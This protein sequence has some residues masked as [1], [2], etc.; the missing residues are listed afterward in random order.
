ALER[1]LADEGLRVGEWFGCLGDE[2]GW[3]SGEAVGAGLAG[4]G[5]TVGE[6]LSSVVSSQPKRL[7]VAD[8]ERR[9]SYGELWLRA[10]AV[11]R[12]L[13]TA[14][15]VPGERVGLVGG[16]DGPLLAG[17]LGIVLAG[18]AYVPLEPW[19]P[20]SRWEAVRAAQGLR[21]VVTVAGEAER[22]ASLGLPL[23]V[24][25]SLPADAGGEALVAVSP[26]APVYVLHTS[27]TTGAPRAVM[28]TQ[29]G[30]LW[31]LARY[32]GSL[33]LG[34]EDRL[35][36]LSGYGYDAALQDVFGALLSGA[37]LHAVDVQ[38][39]GLD[40]AG[41]LARLADAGVT[42]LHATP[43]VYRYLLGA[44]LS[45]RH[46]L[47]SLRWVVLGGEA[48]RASDLALLASRLGPGV[49]LVNGYGLTECTVATRWVGDAR[50]RLR[51]EWLPLGRPVG[52]LSLRLESAPGE[53]GWCGEIVLRAAGLAA[54]EGEGESRVYRT[55]DLAYWRADGELMYAGR[56]DAQVQLGGRRLELDEVA[57]VLER[58]AA[59]RAAAAAV[60]PGPDGVLR[61]AGY[62]EAAAELDPAELRAHCRGWLADWAVPVAWLRLARLPRRA[63][64]KLDRDALPAPRWGAAG[65]RLPAGELE[66]QIA[67]LCA[68]LLGRETIGADD[69]F[70]ALGGHSLLALQLI[71]RI[72]EQTG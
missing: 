34:R 63:N 21:R 2:C 49:G 56:R 3:V 67:G 52:P 30:L 12:A 40:G 69:D 35:S 5:E 27:G 51:G 33:G 29:A 55:G 22:A 7:A 26:D 44:E 32:A 19:Q 46:E 48:A 59:V 15:L 57:A 43:T 14:G 18:G 11:S 10:A 28:Q 6:V 38:G 50:S 31:Q 41:V 64:G 58:H 4:A 20:Q 66:R 17:L 71:A 45:C 23:V 37:S 42:V 68:E 39:G 8:G 24:V 53:A 1:V 62:Y 9:W 70:F 54:G 61:L 72:R 25:E 36:W 60:W 47:G 13:Q 16:H 65:R